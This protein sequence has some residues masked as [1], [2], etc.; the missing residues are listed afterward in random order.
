MMNTIVHTIIDFC[1]QRQLDFELLDYDKATEITEKIATIFSID[2]SIKYPWENLLAS[3]NFFYDE[4]IGIW[5]K[6]WMS[7]C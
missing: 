7:F 4:D 5:E 6:K 3:K 2:L 1:K